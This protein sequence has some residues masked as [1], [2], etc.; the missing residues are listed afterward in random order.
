MP[1]RFSH[2]KQIALESLKSL[3]YPIF[4]LLF[5]VGYYVICIFIALFVEPRFTTIF[6]VAVTAAKVTI[7]VHLFSVTVVLSRFALFIVLLAMTVM[8]SARI[9]SL[10][11]GTRSAGSGHL[12]SSDSGGDLTGELIQW[13]NEH[14]LLQSIGFGSRGDTVESHL[15]FEKVG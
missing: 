10:W 8:R 11:I 3:I 6:F 14:G 12:E 1:N 7:L 15:V 13:T 2:L 5:I 9:L 4:L